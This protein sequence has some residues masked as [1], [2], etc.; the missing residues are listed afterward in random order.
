MKKTFIILSSLLL[1]TCLFNAC[2]PQVDIEAAKETIIAVNE[3]ERD[4]FFA[5]DITEKSTS[6]KKIMK[7]K[8][9][10]LALFL[11]SPFIPRF[12]IRK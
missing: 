2:Q 12:S 1:F 11:R 4:A 3:E 6:G 10:R 8:S 9:I 7:G 5:K